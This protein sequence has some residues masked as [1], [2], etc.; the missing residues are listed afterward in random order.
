MILGIF[1]VQR[2]REDQVYDPPKRPNSN[3]LRTAVKAF[4]GK[5]LDVPETLPRAGLENIENSNK[6][7]IETLQPW[8][9]GRYK[10]NIRIIVK[11]R[12]NRDLQSV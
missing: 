3:F 9:A 10:S 6:K 7:A 4:K 2:F 5:A 11:P 8:S 1:W 12:L